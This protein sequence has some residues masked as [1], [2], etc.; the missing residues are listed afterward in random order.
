MDGLTA[1][2]AIRALEAAEERARTPI[3]SLTADALSEHIQEAALAGADRHLA[4]P[5]TT[6]ALFATLTAL[7]NG[8]PVALGEAAACI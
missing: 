5:V 1:I 3:V 7:E 8:Q 2:R 6:T 4:K